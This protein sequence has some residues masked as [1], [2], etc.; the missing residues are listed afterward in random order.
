MA[1]RRPKI[2]AIYGVADDWWQNVGAINY[3]AHAITA[4]GTAHPL[5]NAIAIAAGGGGAANH[6]DQVYWRNQNN[7]QIAA[8]VLAAGGGAAVVRIEIDCTLMPCA[9]NQNACVY[10]VPA[11]ING[12]P[13][14][15]GK[16]LRIFSHRNEG[17][18]GQVGSSNRVFDC[19]AGAGNAALL[20]AFNAN[21]G[22]G[23]VPW[24]PG[25]VCQEI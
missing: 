7:A 12:K 18:P 9:N 21:R 24:A 25:Y 13:G 16:P 20:A 19:V 6:P 15:A 3:I 8:G 14:L 4:A 2:A 23:W 11:L 5:G 22:W 17:G 10:R 1:L